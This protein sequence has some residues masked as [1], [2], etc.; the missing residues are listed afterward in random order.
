MIRPT[1]RVKRILTAGTAVCLS[2]LVLAACSSSS[3]STPAVKRSSAPASMTVYMVTHACP[4]DAFWPPVFNG[5]Q[6]AA[7]AL[8]VDLHIIRFTSAQCG[9]IPAEVS[10]LET[11][12]DAHPGGII[13][14]IPSATAFS[15]ALHKAASES[16]PVIAVN[17]VPHDNSQSVNPYLAYVG[18]SNYQAGIGAGNEAISEFH[19]AKGATVAIVDHEPFN[20]SLTSREQGIE[21]AFNSA[22]VK[23]TIVNTTDNPSAGAST[24]QAFITVHPT[25]T[26]YLSLGTTGTTQIVTALQQVGKLKKINV[27]GFDLDSATLHYIQQGEVRFTVDQQPFLQGYDS[28]KELYLLHQY[29]VAPEN[30]S[31]GPAYLTAENIASVGKYVNETGF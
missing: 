18:Q 27:G 16:I 8:G 29:G 15:S 12:I 30:I 1:I 25:V 7:S 24:V 23:Y 6:D 3:T 31:T 21:S 13:T 20:I 19:L 2:A 10:N 22:G 26:T 5:A 17:T 14:T 4:S 9:S 28:V 11:A